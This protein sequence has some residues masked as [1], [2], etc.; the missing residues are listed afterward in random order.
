MKPVDTQQQDGYHVAVIEENMKE[1]YGCI[2]TELEVGDLFMFQRKYS[3]LI[4]KMI[5]MGQF[6]RITCKLLS[7]GLVYSFNFDF[8]DK[9]RFYKN[10]PDDKN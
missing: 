8:D 3:I 4:D 7:S 6:Y 5:V 10:V 9:V 2:Y 1:I